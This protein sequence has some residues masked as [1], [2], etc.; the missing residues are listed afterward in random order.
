MVKTQNR[1]HSIFSL[2]Q[3]ATR[4]SLAG[5]IG[6]MI[7]FL[8]MEGFR[9]V[10]IL[11]TAMIF[12]FN[13]FSLGLGALMAL[14]LA[15]LGS[16]FQ[17]F[18][19]GAQQ[20]EMFVFP[21]RLSLLESFGN[22]GYPWMLTVYFI[23]SSCISGV[24][25]WGLKRFFRYEIGQLAKETQT[26]I[27]QDME[28][29]RWNRIKKMVSLY[30]LG[31][32]LFG[33][34]MGGSYFFNVQTNSDVPKN[35]MMSLDE[36]MKTFHEE[37]FTSATNQ[38]F[39]FYVDWDDASRRSLYDHINEIDVVM[40]NWLSLNTQMKIQLNHTEDIDTFLHANGRKICPVINNYIN[41]QWDANAVLKMISSKTKRKQF[42]EDA[43][44]MIKQNGYEGINIDFEG[45]PPEAKNEFNL[46]AKELYTEF[47]KNQLSV[48][49]DLPPADPAFDYETIA[50]Y[51]DQVILML[52]DEHSLD[53]NPGPIAS[54]SWFLQCLKENV[55]PPDKLVV[56]LGVF[57]YDWTLNTNEK[58]MS[59]SYAEVMA[60]SQERQLDPMWDGAVGNPY[61]R[62]K[63]D[64]EEHVLWYLNG[65][66][67]YN[68]LLDAKKL[69]YHQ[70]ALWRLGSEDPNLW[71]VFSTYDQLEEAGPLLFESMYPNA[72]PHLKPNEIVCHENLG[73]KKPSLRMMSDGHLDG[74]DHD[75]SGLGA[76][77]G[78]TYKE[79]ALT[80]DDGPNSLYT[81]Q[82]LEILK[83]H[84]V[85]AT[86]FV[87]GKNVNDQPGLLQ[88]IYEEGHCIGNHTYSHV[89]LSSIGDEGTK[90]E[91]LKAQREIQSILGRSTMLFRQPYVVNVDFDLPKQ[92]QI[93]QNANRSGYT[94]VNSFIDPKDWEGPKEEEIIT[95]VFGQLE[96]GNI[97]LLHDEGEHVASMIKTLPLLIER[98][99]ENGYQLKTVNE[100]MG[101][102]RSVVMPEVIGT[103]AVFVEL[104]HMFGKA[105]G[106]INRMITVIFVLGTIVGI[107]R[108][109]FFIWMS[110]RQK[111]RHEKLVFYKGFC[112]P[113]SIVIAAY[114]E[115]KVICNTVRSVLNSDYENMEVLVVDDGSKDQTAHVVVNAFMDHPKVR[116]IRKENGGK[117]SAVNKGFKE[118]K[119]EIV[120]IID[121]DTLLAE[122]AISLM[123]RHFEDDFV[124]A[125][126]GN[127]KIGN[128]S[129]ILTTWQ[130]IEYVTGLN[131]E[132][133]A[134]D[135]LNCIPVV[136][137]A[138]GAWR[139]YLV[140][141]LGYYK[142]DTLAED[143]DITLTFLRKGY[144]IVYEEGA[145]AYTE[146][147]EDLVSFLKQR[148]RW[149]YGTLQCLWK[150]RNALFYERYPT[151]GFIAL[152]NMWLYQFLFQTLS[153]LTDVLFVMGLL[154]GNKGLTIL[155]YLAYYAM[156]L[157]VTVFA[158]RL[159][160][161]DL[162][163]LKW[164]FIQRIVYRQ[165]MTYVVFK[166]LI[167][168]LKGVKVGWNKLKRKGNV[169]MVSKVNGKVADRLSA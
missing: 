134:F 71:K 138:I 150:H 95:Q 130:H 18:F 149:S 51:A 25:F 29:K 28:Q 59:L 123:V 152:P 114:N 136:P 48:Q 41:D 3:S 80:F 1:F 31:G 104:I 98:L 119:G 11:L 113:V 42:V 65:M 126:S 73:I 122:N 124:A 94:L 168:A 92:A 127:V 36:P 91:L 32:V 6:M 144:R 75:I 162:N 49:Y 85:K 70:V 63:K 148:L 143:A 139:K 23:S 118:A 5:S 83:A 62:Y 20:G 4:L 21:A 10:V 43:L 12:R 13:V 61:L 145:K 100:L 26:Y 34:V 69:G 125:V 46:L 165:M 142:E 57:G 37:S 140:A 77:K 101:I 156:D 44:Q 89:D 164:V 82:I 33:L 60:L 52:Y 2:K 135:E 19:D 105:F 129:N 50:K 58:A 87:V 161:E 76:R 47:H 109:V 64:E 79:V 8:P 154:A 81:P 141:S 112:P 97:I 17:I 66:A 9:W 106:F 72:L 96:K 102:D 93:Y 15:Y 159:E 24:F 147:P 56:G 14:G 74:Y 131:L 158:F 84:E 155:F 133:R 111:K 7:G 55:I 45:L 169:E 40:P 39:C 99:K 121:A 163:P 151:L 128:K 157:L 137:G 30:L 153:P 115:E 146:A 53:T 167:S 90:L 107:M 117:S 88:K 120:I 16:V 132:R 160:K 54:S 35:E 110:Y 22:M 68:Q 78:E 103:D 116:L 67:I 166:S 108:V 86:F 27:F 38:T